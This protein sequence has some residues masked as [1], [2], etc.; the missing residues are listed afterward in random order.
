MLFVLSGNV[1][2]GKTR[3]LSQLVNHLENKGI[4]VYGVTAPGIWEKQ[5]DSAT[6]EVSFEK[7]GIENVLLPQNEGIL[8]A[9]RRDIAQNMGRFDQHSQS[10]S[11]QML[12]E[13]QEDAIACVNRHFE[14]L[15]ADMNR[16]TCI[17]PSLG[18][19]V[20]DEF[21][22]LELVRNQGL[23]AAIELVENGPNSLYQHALIVVRQRL[24]DI[25]IDRFSVAWSEITLIA[26]DAFGQK[27][28]DRV[29]CIQG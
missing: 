2:T 29:F 25:A 19:L 27:Q 18:I 24:C 21:G 26:P 3:W 4:T 14:A 28:V 22:Q 16:D 13:I 1:Q 17:E 11:A 10:T 15:A 7:L 20:V 5:A 6:G 12:W 8:F 23:R 9:L